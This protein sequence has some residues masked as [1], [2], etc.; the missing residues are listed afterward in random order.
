[1][2]LSATLAPPIHPVSTARALVGSVRTGLRS[3]VCNQRPRP[4]MRSALHLQPPC[5]WLDVLPSPASPP[6]L[7]HRAL[8]LLWLPLQALL[9]SRVTLPWRLGLKVSQLHRPRGTALH[10]V[11]YSP[12][13]PPTYLLYIHGL[14]GENRASVVLGTWPPVYALAKVRFRLGGEFGL[15][16]LSD[17][18]L[19]PVR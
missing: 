12:G 8:R 6:V 15:R 16:L 4:L 19:A 18:S 11:S 3:T 5:P 9:P 10:R 7:R 13:S 2:G 17:P 1:M 14:R